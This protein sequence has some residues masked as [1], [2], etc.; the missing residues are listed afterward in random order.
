M[1]DRSLAEQAA[2][3]AVDARVR[4]SEQDV[5][6]LLDE[7]LA[8]IAAGGADR[9]PRLTDIIRA[10][11]LS[12]QAFYRYFASK[13]DLVAAIVDDGERRLV[14]YVGRQLAQA[15]LPDALRV[16][17]E[18]VTSQALDPR[19]AA[20]T[21]AVLWNA[22]RA[23]DSGGTR[24]RQL[25]AL[26]AELLAPS[27]DALGSSDPARDAAVIAGAVTS[28]MLDSLWQQTPPEPADVRHLLAFCE[29]GLRRR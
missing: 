21:R 1:D 27:L 23:L 15:A 9:P 12:N 7:G 19:V 3:R 24:S 8:L 29:A 4:T 14:A 6:R 22:G 26:L 18:A 2:H 11:G 25:H 28:F 17:V 16:F 20:A 10:A 13:D 5:R